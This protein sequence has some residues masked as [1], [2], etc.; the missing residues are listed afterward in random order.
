MALP[1]LPQ[2]PQQPQQGQLTDAQIMQIAQQNPSDE[3]LL[4]LAI[5]ALPGWTPEKIKMMIEAFRKGGLNNGQ[6]IAAAYHAWGESMKGQQ[7]MPNLR[8]KLMGP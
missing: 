4:Q 6:I 2:Q 8:D 3:Q 7:Y 1:Q 5:Q